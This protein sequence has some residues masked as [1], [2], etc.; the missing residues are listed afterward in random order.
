MGGR[1]DDVWVGG[2][3]GWIGGC[4]DGQMD[5]QTEDGQMTNVWMNGKTIGRR[6]R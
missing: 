6:D 2:W 4:K 1:V 5:E 3:I